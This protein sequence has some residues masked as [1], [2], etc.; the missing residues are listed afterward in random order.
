MWTNFL[1]YAF[2]AICIPA[3]GGLL[4]WIGYICAKVWAYGAARGRDLYRQ[5]KQEKKRNGT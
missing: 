5:R 2:L 1:N 3:V 4:L